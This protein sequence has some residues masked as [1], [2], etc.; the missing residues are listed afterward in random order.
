VLDSGG[1]GGTVPPE[2]RDYLDRLVRRLRDALGD[3]LVG[4]YL[5]GSAAIGAFVPS[6]SDVD[7]LVVA[8]RPLSTEQKRAIAS[9]LTIT[10]LPCPGVGLELTVVEAGSMRRVVDAPGFELHLDL[11]GGHH[12][13]VVDGT[14]QDGDPDLIAL[15][16][17]A[18][19]RGIALF[20]PLPH[21]VF[22]PIE[23]S[24]LLRTFVEDLDWGLKHGHIGY[25]VLNACRALRYAREGVLSSKPE[26][27]VW[28]ID[29][30]IGDR[31]TIDAALRRQAGSD[32]DVDAT[33]GVA[34]VKEI[35]RELSS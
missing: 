24:R 11:H 28:A 34:L 7:I 23:R 18:R 9:S 30:S 6:R 35:R 27:G 33:H 15:F 1:V 25:A 19:E 32:E 22:P 8:A 21:G 12:E 5:H 26:G 17:M 2:L 20:G 16:A 13:R 3:A 31:M 14:E 10:A 29:R 4:I